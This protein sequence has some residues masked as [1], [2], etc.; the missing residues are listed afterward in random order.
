MKRCPRV[1]VVNCQ[2]LNKDNATGITLRSLWSDWDPNCFMEIYSDKKVNDVNNLCLRSYCIPAQGLRKIVRGRIAQ[3]A[4]IK[5][6]TDNHTSKNNKQ[7]INYLR[8]LIVCTLDDYKIKI[9]E[10]LMNSIL[11]FEP[12]VIYT[13]GASVSIMRLANQLSD[14]LRIPIVLHFM[15]NWAESIQWE[16]NHFLV[17]YEHKLKKVMLKCISRCKILITI[18]PSMACV[19]EEMFKKRCITLMNSVD[20]SQKIKCLKPNKNRVRFVYAGGLHLDRWKSLKKIAYC[21]K[22]VSD[23]GI[24]EIYTSNEN[25]EHYKDQFASLPVLF[26]DSV[27]HDQI[28]NIY[29]NAD[30]LIHTEVCS[31]KYGEFFKYSISTKIPE[32]L[33]S[34]KPI[35]FYGPKNIELYHY[36]S[37]ND[38]ALTA[39]TEKDL[40]ICLQR[41]VSGE[42]FSKMCQDA[43]N[44]AKRN[45]DI[46]KNQNKLA[47]SLDEVV[48]I[49]YE[50]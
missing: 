40:I 44:L 43:L 28:D 47:E 3:S 29:R 6:K 38:A 18:S 8:Q 23:N 35:L 15:D 46:K 45:H 50:K 2:S 16:N 20:V 21:I 33:V 30:V 42:D 19:Y 41:L 39:S 12:E 11:E 1:L 24:L 48:N 49:M 37:I 25:R 14:Q 9:S 26:P 22:K 10:S 4:N 36:L 5:I 27:P 31:E 13:L 7:F 32:Y 34:G 17:P